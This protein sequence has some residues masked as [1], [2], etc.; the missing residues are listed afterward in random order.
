M[1]NEPPEDNNVFMIEVRTASLSC[2]DQTHASAAPGTSRS[3]DASDTPLM[4]N[5]HTV[6]PHPT[7][8]DRWARLFASLYLFIT[9]YLGDL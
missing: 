2:F 7:S 3:A 8:G 9:R 1:T 6:Y 5:R 4:A